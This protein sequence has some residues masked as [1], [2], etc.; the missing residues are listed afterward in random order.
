MSAVRLGTRRSRLALAQSGLVADFL[1]S[2]GVDVDLVEIATLGDTSPAALTA[3]GGSGVFVSALRDALVTGRCDL[4]VHSLK[5]LPTQPDPRLRIAAVPRRE[6]PRDA[7]CAAGGRT[8]L[9][10]SPGSRVGTGSPRRAAQLRAL[11]LGVE[12]VPVRGNVDTRLRLVE[13]GEVDAVLLARA[14]L[15]RLGRLDAITQVLDPLQ[16]LPAPGQGALA[17]ETTSTAPPA[18]VAALHGLDDWSS[19]AAVTAERALLAA[20]EAG[21]SAPVGALAELAEGESS[22]ELSLRA[23][24]VALDGAESV[25]LSLSVPLSA[26]PSAPPSAPSPASPEAALSLPSGDPLDEASAAGRR[27]AAALLADGAAEL[28]DGP[29]SGT[30]KEIAL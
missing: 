15:A 1:R 20:L 29:L 28:V 9:D 16:F 12:V 6:D 22:P 10:V 25:R 23:V 2:R 14:G 26:A 8:L 27:L 21:C 18:L 24:V 3:L 30:H 11:G 19:R 7:L 13:S 4:A 17:V 5:D